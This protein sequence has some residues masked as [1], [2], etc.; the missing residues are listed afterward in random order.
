[1]GK[2]NRKAALLLIVLSFI[3]GSSFILMKKGLDVYSWDQVAALRVTLAGLVLLPYVILKFKSIIKLKYILLFAALEVGFPPFLYTYAQTV[4]DSSS[5]GILNSLVPLFT[6]MTGAFIF[7][8]KVNSSK[9]A[10]V[11]IGL[12]GALFL[13]LFKTGEGNIIDLS[14]SYGLLIV[15]ATL[16]YGLGGNVLKEKLQDVSSIL[17]AALSFVCMGIPT[18]L[19][20]LTTDF[21]SI[22]LSNPT[23]LQ[24]FIAIVLLSLFGSALAIMLF[25]IL[26]KKSNALFG[27]F[28]TYLIPFVAIFWGALDGENINYK[29]FLSLMVILF[30]IFIAN[31]K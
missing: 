26:V 17:I 19:Y 11:F 27:S 9:V 7:G 21:L 25:N 16:M 1:M 29:H 23:N 13:I 5:A 3:W 28:V 18:G 24:A 6:L 14:N 30:G 20:L 15:L 12:L 2:I 4:V 10:G 22:P 8:V 31:R